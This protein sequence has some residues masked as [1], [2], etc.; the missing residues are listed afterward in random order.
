MVAVWMLAVSRIIETGAAVRT[1]TLRP[2][3]PSLRSLFSPWTVEECVHALLPH[4]L[5]PRAFAGY[6]VFA[7]VL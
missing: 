2:L 5:V 6:V 3:R 7:V 1:E 4:S